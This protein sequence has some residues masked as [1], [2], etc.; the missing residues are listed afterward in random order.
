MIP[1]PPKSTLT[2]TRLPYTSLFLSDRPVL[3]AGT[4]ESDGGIGL[5]LALVARQQDG[6]ET[7][8]IVEERPESGIRLDIRGDGRVLAGAVAQRA[9]IVRVLQEAHVEHQIGLARQAAAIREGRDEHVH[10]RLAPQ[11]ELALEQPARSEEHTSEL[12]SLM[13]SSY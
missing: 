6:E 12:Q 8:Q 1:R 10:R 13:R 2:D 7:E 3:A 9:H 11:P 5:A 4:A